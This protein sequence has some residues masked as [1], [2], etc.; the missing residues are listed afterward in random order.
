M[1]LA[2]GTLIGY[3]AVANAAAPAT[4]SITVQPGTVGNALPAGFAG[5]SLPPAELAA[6][7]FAQTNLGAYLTTLGGAGVIRV[8][9]SSADTTFWTSTGETAP[10][11]A[12]GTI[13]P[14]SLQPL[15]AI[16]KASGWRVILGVNLEHYDP[17]R[18]ADEAKNA[19]QILGSSLLGIEVGNDPNLYYTSTSTYFTAF[20]A[21]AAA[22]GQA[23]PGVGLI[24]PDPS[25]NEPGFLSA[26]AS[27]EAVHPDIAE[28]A[29]HLYPTSACNGSAA[30]IPSLLGSS[31][32]QDE[33][34][35][36][37]ALA[38]VAR[39][40]NVPAAVDE[41]NSAVCGGTAG[42]SDVFAASLWALDNNLLLAQ[43]GVAN[44]DFEGE[45]SACEAYSP[46]CGSGGALTAQPVFYGLLATALVGTGNFVSVTNP[47]SA[48]VRAY[49]VTNGNALTVVL[50]DVQDPSGNGPTAVSLNLGANYPQGQ[51]TVLATSSSAGLS[52]KTGITIGGQQIGPD[53]SFPAPASTPVTV[54][55]QTAT[56]TVNA[57]SAAIIK[58]SGTAAPRQPAGTSQP[59]SAPT[60]SD[61]ST[62]SSSPSAPSPSAMPSSSA[63]SP[64]GSPSSSASSSSGSSSS[65]SSTSASGSGGSLDGFFAP[66]FSGTSFCHFSHQNFSISNGELTTSYPAGSSSQSA[67]APFGGAQDCIPAAA[68]PQPTMTL[69]YSV[70][71]PVGFQFVKG[72]KLPGIYGGVEPFSGGGHNSDGWSMRLMWRGGGAGEVYSYTA[73]STGFGDDYGEGNF[74][75][76]ADGN[77]HTVSEHVTINSPG[78]SDGSVTLSYDGKQVI[79]QTGIDVTDTNT[80]AGG[81]FFSTFY[82]GHDSSWAPSA[83]ESVSFKDFSVSG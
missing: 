28:V 57:G 15:A 44:A 4:T 43:N 72:G 47:D 36:A 32:A 49:A 68:G 48:N 2:A 24:G 25:H 53:G 69:T 16:A 75:W 5:L 11:W 21:Y 13:T 79:D 59:T 14:A 54:T 33:M 10:S 58:F 1:G 23:A 64:S 70:R 38:S 80:P 50:D 20:E 78:A 73:K 37:T 76:Q 62:P 83:D 26:F 30:T 19:A 46:L 3:A 60:P 6:N 18:A 31:S 22:I 66:A 71:F 17:V 12:T 40:L 39:Q 67:G 52:A 41:T 56:V 42:V 74:S 55:G 8:G 63:P 51:M 61:T 82:G 35:G 29:D 34:S 45:I 65:G 27:N 9:G 77:W 81:L 7:D